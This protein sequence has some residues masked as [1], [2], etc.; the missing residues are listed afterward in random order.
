MLER[1][2]G[3]LA[4]AWG[5]LVLGLVLAASLHVVMRKSDARAAV[6]WLG[7]IWLLPVL[8]L[9][10]YW[11]LGINRVQRRATRLRRRGRAM[12]A[13]CEAD[14]AQLELVNL[15]LHGLIRTMDATSRMPLTAGNRVQ[16]LDGG[17]AAYPHMLAGIAAARERVA[18][19]TY[20]FDDDAIGFAFCDALASARARGVD[21]AVLVDAAGIARWRPAVLRRLDAAGVPTRLFH[22][23]HLPLYGAYFNLRNHRKLLVVDGRC[24]WTG[25]MNITAD[26]ARGRDDPKAVLDCQFAVEGPVV[27]WLEQVFL[28]D[29]A[30]TGPALNW[31]P[32]FE[33]LAPV[34]RVLARA[35]PDGPDDDFGHLHTMLV[36]AIN[37]ARREIRIVNPYFLPDATLAQ[38]L[39]LAALR[40]VRVEILI[41]RKSDLRLVRWATLG[42]LWQVL[43]GGCEV[44]QVEPP[45]DHSKLMVVD[46]EWATIGSTNLDPRSLRLNFELNLECYDA[47]LA[48]EI[49]ALI[50]R[51]KARARRI[52][53][54][55]LQIRPFLLRLRDALARLAHPYL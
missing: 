22:P 40:G 18:L 12:Q 5:T 19:L 55:D 9:L 7:F 50:D 10:L 16:V 51:R 53:A 2:P 27:A 33:S 13:V 17:Q 26:S 32:G 23:L 15:P 4:W 38:A 35:V 21:V 41:P 44:W 29:W 25:G 20:I 1:L 3:T 36:A 8:G 30:S 28:E 45:F 24:A 47:G 31:Q 42:L 11:T 48:R 52:T 34:G 6:V 54:E 39:R 49:T 46:G 43:D 37:A 14:D